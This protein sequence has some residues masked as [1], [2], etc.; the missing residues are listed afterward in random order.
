MLLVATEIC[1][2][3]SLAIY[4]LGWQTG[5]FVYVM[6][7]VPLVYFNPMWTY[8]RKIILS[9]I[10][11][12][13]YLGLKY[14]SNVNTPVYFLPPDQINTLYYLNSFCIFLILAYLSYF[15]SR[16]AQQAEKA[17]KESYAKI[18]VLAQTD[19]L[20]KLSNRRDTFEKI[21]S[22]IV[23]SKRSGKPFSVVLTDIDNFKHFNDEYGHDCG[24]FV[25]IA[26]ANTIKNTLRENDH[27]GRWGGEEFLIILP[28]TNLEEAC[29]VAEKIRKSLSEKH[30]T[31]NN[32]D[33]HITMTF[34]IGIYEG[35]T[36][37]GK[38]IGEADKA[39]Y[40]GKQ[41]GKNCV[42]ALSA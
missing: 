20:T 34:G 15:Y 29:L 1:I 12:V 7:L 14:F 35:K 3:A 39:L 17:L 41:Q 22:E 9:L 26:V 19:A 16:A 5:F 21:E 28:E 33:C 23:R 24:D 40:K 32:I 8:T 31:F 13:L 4:F 42:I 11:A 27:V 10:Y 25:L 6:V 36:D 30:Y 18:K 2:H 37:I 38:C